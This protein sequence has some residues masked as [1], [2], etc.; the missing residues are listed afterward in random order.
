MNQL[1]IIFIAGVILLFVYAFIREIKKQ[2]QASSILFKKFAEKFGWS[3]E[4]K[5]RGTIQEIAQDFQALGSFRSPSLGKVI[6]ENVVI[7]STPEGQMY[8]FQHRVRLYEG[9]SFQF[10]VCLIQ[11]EN[12]I[13]ESLVMRF[14]KKES[15]LTNDFYTDPELTIDG[16]WIEGII[17][18]GNNQTEV[19]NLLDDTTLRTLIQHSK[20]LPWRVDLQIQKNCIA[21]YIAERN[22]DVKNETDLTKLMEFTKQAGKVFEKT[23]T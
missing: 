5:D 10:N 19:T 23:K 21:V 4:E 20:N 13:S 12:Y 16:K 9:Y 14:K 2:K 1:L 6:P 3:Y 22:A 18:Y 17:V 8:F 7:G 11:L 15:R